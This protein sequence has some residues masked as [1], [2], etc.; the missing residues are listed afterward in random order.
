MQ[1]SLLSQEFGRQMHQ[2]LPPW[3]ISVLYIW[4]RVL[5]CKHRKY[6]RWLVPTN[7]VDALEKC[8]RHLPSLQNRNNDTE[9]T[10][11]CPPRSFSYL[12]GATSIHCSE[13]SMF[14]SLKTNYKN[15]ILTMGRVDSSV[16]KALVGTWGL[17]SVEILEAITDTISKKN[18]TLKKIARMQ[19][20]SA[21]NFFTEAGRCS[22]R[23][24]CLLVSNN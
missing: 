2:V 11:A 3:I 10:L 9:D 22:L 7:L 19:T 24:Y 21:A 8:L 14:C 1:I 5:G 20:V 16:D 23:V 15:F 12:L 18:F 4:T 6:S 13:W 17:L